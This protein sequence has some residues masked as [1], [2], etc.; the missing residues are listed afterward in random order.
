VRVHADAGDWLVVLVRGK[1]PMFPLRR[2]GALPFAF[3]NPIWVK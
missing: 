3:T 1:K 2:A